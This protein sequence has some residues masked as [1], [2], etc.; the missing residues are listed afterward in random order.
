[1]R[2]RS[3]FRALAKIGLMAA[4]AMLFPAP[5]AT[6][7]QDSP[8]EIRLNGLDIIDVV[9]GGVPARLEVN[10]GATGPIILNPDIAANAN[11]VADRQLTYDYGQS[12]IESQIARASVNFGSGNSNE[13]VA[14]AQ[15][16]VS[17][18]AD[19]VI[20]VQHLP[21]DRITFI[22]G[23]EG[24]V[25]RVQRLKLKR[26]GGRCFPRLGTEVEVGDRKLFA[27][28]TLSVDANYVS[29][30]TANFLATN[31]E[32]GFIEGSESF[33]DLDFGLRRRT[34]DMRLV[35]PIELGELKVDT[36]A[37]RL[38]DHGKADK[39]GDLAADDPRLLDGTII[40]SRRKGQGRPDVVT[41]IGRAEMAHCSRLT[42][43]LEAK[44]IELSCALKD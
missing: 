42:F 11:L 9:V 44:Q 13:R 25:E 40:V 10:P 8:T 41:R 20:G 3:T 39:V 37:V 35:Y 5:A 43:D 28:F 34:K 15:I 6:Q 16:P 36:F 23:E 1:M 14:W 2:P 21:Y 29:A 24:P 30:R 38:N 18:R 27:V 32:G 17:S 33:I 31:L 4:L 19:G 22:L 7:S 12:Q 26:K